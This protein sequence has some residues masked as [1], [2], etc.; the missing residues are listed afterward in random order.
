MKKNYCPR[1]NSFYK[2]IQRLLAAWL[3]VII[4]V[5]VG[6][7]PEKGFISQLFAVLDCFHF[8]SP[9]AGGNIFMSCR[10]SAYTVLRVKP[11]LF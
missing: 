10:L 5:H 1:M 8:I 4:P 3:F 9:L 11:V 2:F 6:K 7:A